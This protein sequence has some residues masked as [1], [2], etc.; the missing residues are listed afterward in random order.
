M[1]E[2]SSFRQEN[3]NQLEHIRDLERRICILEETNINLEKEL[4][5]NIES[6]KSAS[7][8]TSVQDDSA[9]K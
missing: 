9:L 5:S 2:V 8:L 4:R 1:L 3:R 7:R 6:R